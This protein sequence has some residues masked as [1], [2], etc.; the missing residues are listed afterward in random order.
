[1]DSDLFVGSA[2]IEMYLKG[3]QMDEALRV[4]E[5]YPKLD[6]VMWT[7]IVTGYQHNDGSYLALEF[8]SR[9][10]TE[11]NVSPDSVTLVSVLSA[12]AQLGNVMA[13]S[14]VHGFVTKK[15]FDKGLS[16]CNALLNF[17][18]KSGCINAAAMLFTE[19]EQRD[20]ISWA[21]MI[22][23]Y[24]HNGAA[25]EAL[26]LFNEMMCKRVEANSVSVISALQACEATGNLEE[27]KKIHEFAARKGFELDV[28]VSTALIDMYM[29]CSS[30]D[31]AIELF[32]RMA[33]KDAVS[34]MT[35]INGFVQNGMAFK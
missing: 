24:A 32:E 17:Y 16:V 27:G 8:F 25:D 33:K 14:C 9:M 20:V 11:G 5:E 12:S 1:M 2:L 19:M 34:W 23:C 15:G 29:N 21:S 6:I 10:L 18:V 3:G 35:L 30:P 26:N 4:F 7:H 28:F 13:G 31:E 22:S